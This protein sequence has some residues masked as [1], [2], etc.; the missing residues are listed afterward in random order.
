MTDKDLLKM[1]GLNDRTIT[2]TLEDEILNTMDKYHKE[3]L[4]HEQKK[5]EFLSLFKECFDDLCIFME[6]D[7][8]KRVPVSCFTCQKG[9]DLSKQYGKPK[10]K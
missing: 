2:L 1:L 8:K 4:E 10:K 3:H 9:M 5:K 7:P 6:K